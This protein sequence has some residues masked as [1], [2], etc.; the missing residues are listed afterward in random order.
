MKNVLIAALVIIAAMFWLKGRDAERDRTAALR[1]RDA[2]AD[3]LVTVSAHYHARY[4]SIRRVTDSLLYN[5]VIQA[6][7]DS[8]RAD[9][10]HIIEVARYI[11]L[12]GAL[13]ELY[14]PMLDSLQMLH[15]QQVAA[16]QSVIDGYR[17][18]YQTLLNE[19]DVA[20]GLLQTLNVSIK[21]MTEARDGWRRKANPGVLEQVRRGLPWLAAGAIVVLVLR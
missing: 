2:V 8:A 10:L 15:A 20:D 7:A 14:R 9:S 11:E 3:S 18:Q 4:D 19:R 12:R 6:A 5:V 16:L 13:P 17:L 21:D 1:E